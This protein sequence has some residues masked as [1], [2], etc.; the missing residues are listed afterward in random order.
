MHQ[1]TKV[2]PSFLL[3]ILF[4]KSFFAYFRETSVNTGVKR[5][6]TDCLKSGDHRSSH[7]D[8]SLV[9]RDSTIYS[10]VKTLSICF[11]DSR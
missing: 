8:H 9:E 10:P 5:E 1:Q 2:I 11:L 6:S 4:I 7:S 3:R